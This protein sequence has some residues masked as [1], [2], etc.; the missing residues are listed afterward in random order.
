MATETGEGTPEE[1]AESGSDSSADV[2]PADEAPLTG[3]AAP[4][5]GAEE[6]SDGTYSQFT[7]S[8]LVTSSS[9]L[10]GMVAGIASTLFATEMV[11]STPQPDSLLGFGIMMAAVFAQFPLY[12]VIGL[13]PEEF[14]TKTQLYVFAMTF[15]M[16][17]ITW[18]VLLTT[19]G[20]L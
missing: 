4:D 9:T 5:T 20:L 10:L 2:S 1:S 3:D 15:F 7:R 12:S 11:G 17:F 16:W 14:E 8:V 19:R 6:E 13:E 18:T